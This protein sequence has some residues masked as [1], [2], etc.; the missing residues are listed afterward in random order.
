MAGLLAR[1]SKLSR[2]Y[3]GILT[4]GRVVRA[5]REGLLTVVVVLSVLL[6]LASAMIFFAEHAA[7]P[8]Q[9]P[10]IPAA[11]WWSILTLT[12][13]GYGDVFP[14]TIFGRITTGVIA[15]L[16]IGLFALPAGIL[17]AGFLEEVQR[18]RG[19]PVLICPHCGREI[20]G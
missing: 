13:V 15:T 2:H 18:R 16:G 6:V 1:V 9:F 5:K 17:A 14:I 4:L 8:N 3:S 10:S 20:Q 7:Q 12:G 19:Q 11:M